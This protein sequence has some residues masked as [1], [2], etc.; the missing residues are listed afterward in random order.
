[1]I[2]LGNSTPVSKDS[3][4][5]Q[6]TSCAIAMIFSEVKHSFRLSENETV[7]DIFKINKWLSF[8]S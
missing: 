2:N 7:L 3:M 1:M 5:L 4:C 8:R 6:W